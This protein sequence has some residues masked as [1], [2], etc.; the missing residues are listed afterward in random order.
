MKKIIVFG[1]QQIAIDCIKILTNTR[2]VNL[3]AVV[4][5][6]RERDSVFRYPSLKKFCHENNIAYHNP[7]KLDNQFLE[8]I[9]NL[10][11]D[12]CFSIYYRNIFSPDYISIPPM[13]FINI[14]PSLLPKYRGSIPTFWAL[15]NNEREIGVTMH[16]IDSGI[17][18]GDIIAQVK[19]RIP[20]DITGFELN[21]MMAKKG[22]ELF[23]KQLHIVLGSKNKKVKQVEA[24]V[25]Y[26]GPFT[27]NLKII[28]WSLPIGQIK[29]QV[30]ALTKPYG[31]ARTFI[32]DRELIIWEA[33]ILK[34]SKNNL[35]G[36]GRI[37]EVHS[38]KFIVLGV[39]GLL[40][41]RNFELLNSQNINK[42]IKIGNSFKNT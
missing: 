25:T 23:R 35:S 36:Q 29:R 6:E 42:Y 41:I 4:G 30:Q 9:K 28:N 12:L 14:H 19:C 31:G 16:Y 34:T 13:G 38:N 18:S 15:L 2:D 3:L 17:D 21:S 40:L 26:F 7:K 39:D 22:V 24:L 8:L 1:N 5:C 10:K 11:P 37:V 27:Q 20:Q 32:L 33:E